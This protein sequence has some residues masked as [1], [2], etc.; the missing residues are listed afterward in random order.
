M[1]T[2]RPGEFYNDG[3]DSL[4]YRL[5]LLPEFVIYPCNFVNNQMQPDRIGANEDADSSLQ[6]PNK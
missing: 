1:F 2:A 3:D 4:S 6:L 5:H